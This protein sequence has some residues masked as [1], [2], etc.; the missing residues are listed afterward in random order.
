MWSLMTSPEEATSHNIKR[1]I[2]QHT[3]ASKV[4]NANTRKNYNQEPI[5][6]ENESIRRDRNETPAKEHILENNHSIK[7]NKICDN[8]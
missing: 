4:I 2:Y 6:E 5:Y 3:V 7:I 8:C 1:R